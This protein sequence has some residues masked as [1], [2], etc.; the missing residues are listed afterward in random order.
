MS[1]LY[2]YISILTMTSRNKDV[3]LLS[4]YPYSKRRK[5][6]HNFSAAQGIGNIGIL[7]ADHSNPLHKQQ[8]IRYRSHTA[9]YSNFSP[10]IGCHGPQRPYTL[11][12]GYV[13]VGYVDP[14]TYL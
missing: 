9:T 6:Y 11:D 5:Q 8:P 13:L 2:R 7:S 4:G 1:V 12:L 10:E 14:K 3:T